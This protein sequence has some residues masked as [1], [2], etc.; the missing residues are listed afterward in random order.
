MLIKL[1]GVIKLNMIQLN[2]P[3]LVFAHLNLNQSFKSNYNLRRICVKF[4]SFFLI[5]SYFVQIC[6]YLKLML[7]LN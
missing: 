5:E 2:P 7:G 6:L 4:V 3:E 1:A